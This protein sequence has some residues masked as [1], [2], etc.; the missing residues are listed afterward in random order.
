[1]KW[2]I[3]SFSAILVIAVAGL[4]AW[5][6]F[7]QGWFGVVQTSKKETASTYLNSAEQL[8]SDD[9]A[10]LDINELYTKYNAQYQDVRD[11]VIGSDPT[12]WDDA[13]VQKAAFL[14]VYSQRM[15]VYNMTHLVLNSLDIAENAGVDVNNAE[16]GLTKEYREQIRKEATEA[17]GGFDTRSAE[18]PENE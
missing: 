17:V 5:G 14:L 8:R 9:A 11:E 13:T 10:K 1:M 6:I 4:F 12:K 15:K 3:A 18:E 2:V 16:Y 7:T